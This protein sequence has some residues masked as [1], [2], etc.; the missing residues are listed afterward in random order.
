MTGNCKTQTKGINFTQHS[1]W[2]ICFSWEYEKQ[3]LQ[4]LYMYT[5]VEQISKWMVDCECQ[6]SHYWAGKLQIS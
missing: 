4:Q 1:S 3:I 5:G 6:V 2:Y